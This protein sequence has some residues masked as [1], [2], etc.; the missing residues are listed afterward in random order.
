LSTQTPESFLLGSGAKSAKFPS[1]GTVVGGVITED[2]TLQQQKDIN[3]GA[4]KTWDDGNPMM[5]LVVKVQT[6]E[7]DSDDPED[8]GVRA[9]YIKGQMRNAVA[10]AV[11][12]AGAKSLEVGGTLKVA[13]TGDGEPSKK[14][15]TAPKQ[16]AAQ[17]T[18]PANASASFFDSAPANTP[19]GND[20]PPF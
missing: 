19:A 18:K 11:K 1:V 3:T 17:Y 15:F 7:R 9:I 6:D 5:Q 4:L 13:Y 20:A 10:E 8:D 16:Y 12:K 14:G 2:P